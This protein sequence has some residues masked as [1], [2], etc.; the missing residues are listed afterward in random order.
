MVEEKYF[1]FGV[2]ESLNEESEKKLTDE[3][4]Y[5]NQTEEFKMVKLKKNIMEHEKNLKLK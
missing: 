2:F 5:K 3:D 1:K 4:Y